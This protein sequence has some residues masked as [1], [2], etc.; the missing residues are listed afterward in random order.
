MTKAGDFWWQAVRKYARNTALPEVKFE[1]LPAALGDDAPLWG[2]AA[3]AEEALIEVIK[4]VNREGACPALILA[5]QA[6]E[7]AAGVL[8]FACYMAPSGTI[9]ITEFAPLLRK[10]ISRHRQDNAQRS[11][12]P[13]IPKRFPKQS[14]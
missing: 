2:A 1:I 12:T 7:R 8:F 3:L 4:E 6:P 11:A 5:D 14:A 10:C 9:E 13:E